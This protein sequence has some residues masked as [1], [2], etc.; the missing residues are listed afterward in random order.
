M[1]YLG[2][3]KSEPADTPAL[4]LRIQHGL[5]ARLDGLDSARD[6]LCTGASLKQG[7]KAHV[8]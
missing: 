1:S 6:G 2:I 4:A 7:C 5:R 3:I 8:M